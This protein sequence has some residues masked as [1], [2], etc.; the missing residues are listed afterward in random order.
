MTK[1]YLPPKGILEPN[2]DDDRLKYYY[3]PIVGRLYVGRINMTLGLLKRDEFSSILE[4]GYGS[5][6]LMPPSPS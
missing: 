2:N 5:G 1:L 3:V 6:V 4:I